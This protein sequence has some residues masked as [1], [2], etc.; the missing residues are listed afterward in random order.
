MWLRRAVFILLLLPISW[1]QSSDPLLAEGLHLL[2]EGRTTLAEPALNAARDYFVHLT[3]QSSGNAAYWYEL[4][5]VH[6]YRIESYNNAGNHK[7]ADS[8]LDDA[9]AAVQHAL[10]LDSQ[11]AD[12]HSL[13]AD[14]YGRKI[15]LGAFL[16]GPRFGSKISDEN[17]RAFALDPNN[18]RVHAS[19]GRQYLMAPSMFGGDLDKAIEEF[20]TSIHLAPNFDETYVWLTIACRKHQDKTCADKAMDDALRLNSRSVFAQHFAKPK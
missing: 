20:R 11:S 15:S 14:L 19:L 16:G 4:A 2:E 6:R 18:P 8:A 5:E 1:A 10:Q 13:L 9:M 3:S 17:K 12:A 7:A